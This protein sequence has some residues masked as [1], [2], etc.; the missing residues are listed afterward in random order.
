MS[1]ETLYTSELKHI[2]TIEGYFEHFYYFLPLVKNNKEAY[3]IVETILENNFMT[4]RYSNYDAFRRAKAHH[5]KK[6]RR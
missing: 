1:K 2:N 3:Q 4:N 5:H 6:R